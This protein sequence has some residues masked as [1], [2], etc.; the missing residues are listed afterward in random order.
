MKDQRKRGEPALDEF[1]EEAIT[2]NRKRKKRKGE[3]IEWL[4]GG[5]IVKGGAYVSLNHKSGGRW[6]LHS[7][8][9]KGGKD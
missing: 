9:K 1:R 2:Y 4:L 3:K 7:G 8:K 5:I 6:F